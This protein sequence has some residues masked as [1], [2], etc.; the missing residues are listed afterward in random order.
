MLALTARPLSTRSQGFSRAVGGVAL[1]AANANDRD[2]T[3][4]LALPF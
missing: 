3:S 4:S 2:K 1:E